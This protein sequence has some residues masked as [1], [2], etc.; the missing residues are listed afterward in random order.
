MEPR[1]VGK[2]VLETG[3]VGGWGLL[4]FLNSARR[5][6]LLRRAQ[7]RVPEPAQGEI[8]WVVHGFLSK[9]SAKLP[10]SIGIAYGQAL[11]PRLA[12]SSYRNLALSARSG[13]LVRF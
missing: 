11:F 7:R 12:A 5:A 6:G 3:L 2:I 9:K 13:V 8:E 1:E 4:L 10:I